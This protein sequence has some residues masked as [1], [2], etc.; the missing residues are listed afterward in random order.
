V[1]DL[2]RDTALSLA[3]LIQHQD[4]WKPTIVVARSLTYGKNGAR[5]SGNAFEAPLTLVGVVR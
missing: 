4:Q 5:A 3:F 1:T 2:D